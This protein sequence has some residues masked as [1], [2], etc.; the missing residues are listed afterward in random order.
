M[1][2][3][4]QA[5]VTVTC[6]LSEDVDFEALITVTGGDF[7]FLCFFFASADATPSSSGTSS[8]ATTTRKIPFSLIARSL[9]I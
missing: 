3:L 4:G 7:G 9:L 6:W 1:R 8:A 2:P 5:A